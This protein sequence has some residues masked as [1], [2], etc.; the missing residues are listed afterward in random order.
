MSVETTKKD[1]WDRMQVVGTAVGS[2]ATPIVVLLLGALFTQ[3]AKEGETKARLVEVAVDVLKTDPKTT[4]SIP[5]LRDWAVDVIN[6]YSPKP[7]PT[8][9]AR[10]LIN[11]P[12]PGDFRILHFA[13]HAV[14]EGQCCVTCGNLVTCGASV[15]TACGSCS[16]QPAPNAIP[17]K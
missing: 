4:Q 13:A 9:S 15:T 10:D 6:S 5:G 7:L 12:L 2:I 17:G 14:G 16:I 1:L 3:F 8:Q 11:K